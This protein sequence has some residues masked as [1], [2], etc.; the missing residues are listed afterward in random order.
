MA[1]G[2]VE[3]KEFPDEKSRRQFQGEKIFYFASFFNPVYG[4]DPVSRSLF[5]LDFPYIGPVH[6][7]DLTVGLDGPGFQFHNGARFTGTDVYFII[8][9]YGLVVVDQ[10]DLMPGHIQK[11]FI[12]LTFVHVLIFQ[13]VFE[14]TNREIPF[15]LPDC[16][17]LPVFNP[18]IRMVA[19]G[20][21]GLK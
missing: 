20:G 10:D 2:H 1:D 7:N 3:L 4:K 11:L 9:M 12:I 21:N 8:F 14:H 13:V 18:V 6:F 15:L 17:P 16:H 19:R 5:I